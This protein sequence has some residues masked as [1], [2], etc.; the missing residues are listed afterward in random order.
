M[1]VCS[2]VCS[3]LVQP[4]MDSG[5]SP[6]ASIAPLFGG[7]VCNRPIQL[8]LATRERLKLQLASK[9]RPGRAVPFTTGRALGPSDECDGAACKPGQIQGVIPNREN[10]WVRKKS[11][12][13]PPA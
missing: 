5:H 3:V 4:E 8:W 2:T 1:S 13:L 12:A 11:W 6:L 7:P 9:R 10:N